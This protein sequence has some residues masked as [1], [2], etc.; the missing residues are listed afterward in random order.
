V[1]AIVLCASHATFAGAAIVS[2]LLFLLLVKI[3]QQ[4]PGVMMDV[5]IVLFHFLSLIVPVI[6][7]L[8]LG[9]WFNQEA[10]S[11]T[12]IPGTYHLITLTDVLFRPLRVYYA[13]TGLLFSVILY[14]LVFYS[15]VGL[16]DLLCFFLS[17]GHRP[18]PYLDELSM[19]RKATLNL[20]SLEVP[21]IEVLLGLLSKFPK[22]RYLFK[23][24]ETP[25][26]RMKR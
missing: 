19:N 18:V 25:D 5:L 11:T 26:Q 12:W 9:L 6:P 24:A 3:W 21:T 2:V 7:P 10:E 20:G 22:R 14:I 17:G 8:L 16:A 15:A 23:K 4:N 1:V 13:T